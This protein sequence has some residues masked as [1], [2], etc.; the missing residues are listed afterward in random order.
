MGSKEGGGW[1]AH[2]WQAGAA[3]QGKQHGDLEITQGYKGEKAW[4]GGRE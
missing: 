1:E 4:G 2:G 3:R